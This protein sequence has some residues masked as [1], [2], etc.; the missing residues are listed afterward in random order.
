MVNLPPED[1]PDTIDVGA[2]IG[3]SIQHEDDPRLEDERQTWSIATRRGQATHSA[4]ELLVGLC[5][6]G[7]RV[8][9]E[10]I[11]RLVARAGDDE[12]TLPALLDAAVKD[13]SWQGRDADV[14]SLRKFEADLGN[15]VLRLAEKDPQPEMRWSAS[16][17]LQLRR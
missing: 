15:P 14:M 2:V 8:R 3:I 12:R 7:C 4:D 13:S 5:D 10:V 9:H 16:F 11:D 17:A 1:R 6:D